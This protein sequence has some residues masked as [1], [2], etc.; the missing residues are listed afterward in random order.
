MAM[1]IALSL[2]REIYIFSCFVNLT[3]L[4]GRLFSLKNKQ[5]N[6]KTM[7]SNF[8]KP[9]TLQYKSL[10][11]KINLNKNYNHPNLIQIK[12]SYNRQKEQ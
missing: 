9:C 12:R 8:T 6:C 3:S 7:P 11:Y 10:N 2:H 4:K 1:G 5:K